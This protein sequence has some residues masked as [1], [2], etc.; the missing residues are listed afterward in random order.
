MEGKQYTTPK[1]QIAV[2]RQ[3]DIVSTSLGDFV[4]QGTTLGW[5]DVNDNVW[6]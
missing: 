1:L 6:G 4:E 3:E 5:S 2:F